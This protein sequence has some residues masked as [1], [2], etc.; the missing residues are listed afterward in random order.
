MVPQ[1]HHKGMEWCPSLTTKEWNGAPY[2]QK[3]SSYS[4]HTLS[5]YTYTLSGYSLLK[6]VGMSL[7]VGTCS[8]HQ[9]YCSQLCPMWYEGGVNLGLHYVARM[10]SYHHWAMVWGQANGPSP[11]QESDVPVTLT[12]PSQLVL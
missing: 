5:G 12:L 1:S 9:G 3:A 7:V 4:L 2:H 8:L 10:V 11:G 6:D